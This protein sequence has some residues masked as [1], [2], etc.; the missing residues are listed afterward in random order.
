MKIATDFDV[1]NKPAP[2]AAS[3][4]A[5]GSYDGINP[6]EKAIPE[7]PGEKASNDP[8]AFSMTKAQPFGS[9]GS[10]YTNKK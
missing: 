1:V 9:G 6:H 4:T 5:F 3:G 2:S 8:A 7:C 10:G